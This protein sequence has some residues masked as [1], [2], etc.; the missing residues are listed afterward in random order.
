MPD[1]TGRIV[2]KI[3]GDIA[4]ESTLLSEVSPL[5]DQRQRGESH[6]VLSVEGV[7]R[8]DIS[9]RCYPTRG[10][11]A[12]SPLVVVSSIQEVRSKFGDFT[13]SDLLSPEL[14]QF[15]HRFEC[16]LLLDHFLQLPERLTTPEIGDDTLG[17]PFL[18]QR[19][20]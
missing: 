3:L 19:L 13:S 15:S 10:I 4:I 20:G 17:L 6:S 11:S 1:L 5:H 12:R 18:E 16:G 14:H 2:G 7:Q 9:G 8:R